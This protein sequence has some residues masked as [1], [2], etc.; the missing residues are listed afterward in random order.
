MTPL[1]RTDHRSSPAAPDARSA[2]RL[3]ILLLSLVIAGHASTAAAHVWVVSPDGSRDFTRIQEAIQASSHGDEIQVR[4][5]DYHERLNFGGRRIWVHSTDGAQATTIDA[6]GSGSVVT[7][8]YGEGASTILQGFTLTGGTGTHISVA[9]NGAGEV[10]QAARLRAGEALVWTA[11]PPS[12]KEEELSQLAFGGGIVLLSASPLLRELVFRGNTANIGGG[13]YAWSTQPSL[14]RCLFDDN[15]AGNG[16]A[17]AIDPGTTLKARDCRFRNGVSVSGGGIWMQFARVD[18][19][20]CWFDGNSGGEG[21]AV[22]SIGANDP[23]MIERTVFHGNFAGSG[24][25]VYLWES[26]IALRSC[27]LVANTYEKFDLG[28]IYLLDGSSASLD[29][30]IVAWNGASGAYCES[31][32]LNAVCSDFFPELPGCVSGTS[33]LN[34]DPRFCGWESGNL[35]LDPGSPC[36][37]ESSDCGGIGYTD[38]RCGQPDVEAGQGKNRA[39]GREA[40]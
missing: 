25:A 3:G 13:L 30:C 34:L 16:A 12:A 21:G 39:E 6:D 8:A 11:R 37:P 29:H 1:R 22:Y 20:D 38:T 7:M 26:T 36:L 19:R 24:S 5:G 33:N 17:V 18:L 14:E 35:R 32:S 28:A 10:E 23:G 15:S 27:T 31:S 4:P 2:G 40:P 9:P